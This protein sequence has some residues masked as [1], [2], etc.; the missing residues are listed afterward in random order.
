MDAHQPRSVSPA[1]ASHPTR[2]HDR[3][4]ARR[5]LLL[6]ATHSIRRQSR[7]TNTSAPPP[8][9]AG[10]NAADIA[11]RLESRP[12]AAQAACISK[13]SRGS[14]AQTLTT[15]RTPSLRRPAILA[16]RRLRPPRLRLASSISSWPTDGHGKR[17]SD[18]V[19]ST[20]TPISASC[21]ATSRTERLELAYSVGARRKRKKSRGE[22]RHLQL[23]V[24]Q[25]AK[26]K[27]HG[28]PFYKPC[29]SKYRGHQV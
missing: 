4:P 24:L 2:K 22:L 8:Q 18:A 21:S 10:F 23:V 27:G 14:V 7:P 11:G 15:G 19:S 13:T 28:R 5:P 3:H 16:N 9:A 29:A 20:T 6:P 25:Q 1:G 12:T 26:Q 17:Q